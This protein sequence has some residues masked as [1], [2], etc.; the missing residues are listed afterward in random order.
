MTKSLGGRGQGERQGRG[1]AAML[2]TSDTAEVK[3]PKP[4]AILSIMTL[5]NGRQCH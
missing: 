4:S 2:I 1:R 3:F 5:G